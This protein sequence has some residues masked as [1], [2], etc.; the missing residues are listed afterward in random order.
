MAAMP[1]PKQWVPTHQALPSQGWPHRDLCLLP[2]RPPPPPS[3]SPP[4][5]GMTA[6]ATMAAPPMHHVQHASMAMPMGLI[7]PMP[8]MH[9]MASMVPATFLPGPPALPLPGPPALPPSAWPGPWVHP[10]PDPIQQQY[11]YQDQTHNDAAVAA[12]AIA[13]VTEQSDRRRGVLAHRPRDK[14]PAPPRPLVTPTHKRSLQRT[15]SESSSAK[16]SRVDAVAA[17]AASKPSAMPATKAAEP[18]PISMEG[19]SRGRG[20]DSGH[21]PRD[22][23]PA[24]P[25]P[26]VPRT[27][28]ESSSANNSRFDAVAAQ[29]ASKPSAM[30]ATK[31]AE[32]P[33]NSVGGSLRGDRDGGT[34]T[35]EDS[36][37]SGSSSASSIGLAAA[38]VP[39]HGSHHQTQR[40]LKGAAGDLG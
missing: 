23:K 32:P 14:K 15:E 2:L 21:G 38:V 39:A 22:K 25:R 16:R 11:Q 10:R 31:A 30:P 24:P 3:G 34:A 18:P 12:E 8:H 5:P 35:L 29:A 13:I 19:S 9:P 28:S 27:V 6:M 37:S 40:H 4:I 36:S 20:G 26:P 1:G 17:P 33:P 7:A